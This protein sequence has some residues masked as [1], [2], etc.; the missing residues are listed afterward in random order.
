[1]EQSSASSSFAW[2][3][4]RAMPPPNANGRLD[5]NK[6]AMFV[7]IANEGGVTAAA[8]SSK[9]PKSS[10]SRA[11]SQLEAEMGVEL[12]IRGGRGLKLTSSG[13]AFFE[14]ASQ[15]IATLADAREQVRRNVAVPHGLV[16]IAA[17]P[18][19]AAWMLA[20][21][22]TDFVRRHPEMEIQL[23]ATGAAV[24]PVRDGFDLVVSTGKL[25]DSS[26]KV[27]AIGTA[28]QGIFGSATYLAERGTPRRPSDL[29]K[30]DCVL[31]RSSRGKEVWTL[32]RTKPPVE[33]VTVTVSGRIQVD[34]LFSTIATVGAHGGLAVL[35][36]HQPAGA[37]NASELV[38]VL[39]DY[40]HVSEVARLVYPA[41]R[42]MPLGITMLIE[43]I[44][45]G[46][47]T[48]CPQA[49]ANAR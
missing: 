36:L 37:P 17:P 30:H 42:H 33:E 39:P 8:A 9:L 11:L 46:A 10:V 48:G 2:A 27:R 7:R 15:G 24:D 22:V 32:A 5:L 12:V 44:V 20:P 1:M 43:A 28:T 26:L 25:V 40:V 13:Q 21:I 4:K 14:L 6:V 3:S 29:A 34:D 35:P 31:S 18:S 38:R 49:K 23:C 41:S 47:L 19:F 16:R 45:A